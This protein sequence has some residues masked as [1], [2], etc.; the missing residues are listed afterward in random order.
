MFGEMVKTLTGA[1]LQ[2]LSATKDSRVTHEQTAEQITWTLT[3]RDLELLPEQFN[4]SQLKADSSVGTARSSK[5]GNYNALVEVQLIHRRR[6]SGAKPSWKEEWL[7]V[8]FWIAS[9]NQLGSVSVP[10][11]RYTAEEVRAIE[12]YM[13]TLTMMAEEE[14]KPVNAQMHRSLCRIALS[15]AAATPNS[16]K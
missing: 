9:M 15:A 14:H 5:R 12:A 2:H 10:A 4:F 7:D 11:M 6:L 1:T 3:L 8:K 16:A 13:R